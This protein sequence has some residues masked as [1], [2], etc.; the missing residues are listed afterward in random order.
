MEHNK[1]TVEQKEHTTDIFKTHQQKVI[2]NTKG[3]Y[4][5]HRE[6]S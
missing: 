2:Q 4:H 1:I 3:F 5:E 6:Y